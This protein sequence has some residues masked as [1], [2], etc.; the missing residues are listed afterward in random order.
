MSFLSNFFIKMFANEGSR[1]V[2]MAQNFI[3]KLFLQL[4][5]KSLCVSI[6]TKN[7]V[8]TFVKVFRL[9]YF[10]KD[11]LTDLITSTFEV[12][13]YVEF[14]SRETRYKLTGTNS[15]W[16]IFLRKLVVPWTY[17]EISLTIGLKW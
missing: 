12:L 3:C 17:D 9:E 11:V 13:V 16:L 7:V 5:I 1:I 4:K 8:I 6:N 14:T 15:I 10:S 2:H